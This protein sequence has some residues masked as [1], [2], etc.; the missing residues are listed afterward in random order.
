MLPF[1]VHPQRSALTSYLERGP[2]VAAASFEYGNELIMDTEL[3]LPTGESVPDRFVVFRKY[4]VFSH[5]AGAGDGQ[6][7]V[8]RRPGDTGDY[9]EDEY[10]SGISAEEEE[11]FSF[12]V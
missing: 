3:V 2:A 8:D 6:P 4:A 1:G 10:Q 11:D 9:D 12:S 5:G 7:D